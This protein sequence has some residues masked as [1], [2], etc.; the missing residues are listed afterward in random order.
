MGLF[1]CPDIR[2]RGPTGGTWGLCYCP[3]PPGLPQYKGSLLVPGQ[4]RGAQVGALRICTSKSVA[5]VCEGSSKPMVSSG[6]KSPVGCGHSTLQGERGA[7]YSLCPGPGRPAQPGA[8][9]L[10]GPHPPTARGAQ[11]SQST[12]LVLTPIHPVTALPAPPYPLSPPS[13]PSPTWLPAPRPDP[14][15]PVS[16]LAGGGTALCSRVQGHSRLTP[17]CLQQDGFGRCPRREG[18]GW[19]QGHGDVGSAGPDHVTG[20]DARPPPPMAAPHL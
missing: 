15:P 4:G 19:R 12:Q 17:R 14:R 2:V 20:T 10:P 5:R 9:A 8:H 11:P 1:G 13:C 3:C 6:W 18:L 7:R 16:A